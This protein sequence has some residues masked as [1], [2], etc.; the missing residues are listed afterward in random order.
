MIWL[1]SGALPGDEGDKYQP[2]GFLSTELG[3]ASFRGKG[4]DEMKE[5]QEQLL[6][7]GRGGCS[8]SS[9]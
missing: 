8:F 5:N 1:K 3:P 4:L 6:R 9:S 7:S 2:E